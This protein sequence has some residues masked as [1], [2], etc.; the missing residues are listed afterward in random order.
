MDRMLEVKNLSV[1]YRVPIVRNAS[2]SLFRRE[3]VGLLGRNGSGKTTL[4][5]GLT[6]SAKIFGGGAEVCG[7][8]LLTLSHRERAK[9]LSLLSQ[10]ADLPDG[11]SV[12]EVIAM[13]RYAH[14]GIFGRDRRERELVRQAA[15]R[16]GIED[17]LDADCA[18]LS[19]G[20]RQLVHLARVTAQEAP[21]LLLDEPNSALDFENTHRL[22]SEVRRL[23][24]EDGRAVLTVLHDPALALRWCDRLMLLTDGQLSEA[25]SVADSPSEELRS[26]LRRLYPS[27]E[28]G[29]DAESGA[30]FCFPGERRQH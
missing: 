24:R 7:N 21:V 6:G 22:F 13:G 4:L 27:L 20:Q 12:R 11:L 16:F 15:R 26:S 17:L 1:G 5:R 3:V 8:N 23:S 25:I 14:G 28:L 10:R 2:F 9:R 30:F 29:R 19:E 18:A